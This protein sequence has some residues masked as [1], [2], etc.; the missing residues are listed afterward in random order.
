MTIIFVPGK[1]YLAVLGL[2]IV[3]KVARF[4]EFLFLALFGF[5]FSR[6]RV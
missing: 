2:L 3:F 1:I 4:L 5:F 6:M